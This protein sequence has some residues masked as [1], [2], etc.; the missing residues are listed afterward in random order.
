MAHVSLSYRYAVFSP[1]RILDKLVISF[2]SSLQSSFSFP[3][4][5]PSS[6]VSFPTPT[7]FHV[8]AAGLTREIRPYLCNSP[9]SPFLS[10]YCLSLPSWWLQQE[11]NPCIIWSRFL[12]RYHGFKVKT[13]TSRATSHYITFREQVILY[14][15]LLL[16]L[17]QW[18]SSQFLISNTVI[19][20][21][22][23]CK[24]TN[25]P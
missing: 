9:F 12:V 20:M 24:Q 1:M 25:S 11:W 22:S 17:L 6:P 15:L 8:A 4:S 13:P 16:L 5:L 7:H 10:F 23:G 2:S 14:S 18:N 19:V 3:L 21:W